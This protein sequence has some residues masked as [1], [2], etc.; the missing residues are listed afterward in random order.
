MAASFQPINVAT[1]LHTN[2]PWRRD[3]PFG[4]Q[5]LPLDAG[6]LHYVDE[7]PADAERTLLFVHGNPT[8]SFHWRRLIVGLRDAHRC[9]AIDHLGCGLSD[10]PQRGFRLA[11]RVEHLGRLVDELDLRRVTLVAQDWGGAIG[12][13]ALLDR[14][15]RLDRVLLFNTGAWPPR[16]V[17]ARIAVCKTPVLGKLALQGANLFSLAALRMTLNRTRLDAATAEAYL[18]PYNNW[19]NRRAVYEFVADIPRNSKHPT[20]QTLAGIESRLPELKGLPLRLV[21]GMRDW[22]FD[23]RCLARFREIWHDAAALEVHELADAGHWV[24]EDAPEECIEQL[25]SFEPFTF[26]AAHFITYAGD[27]CEPLHGHNYRVSV[28]IDGP[29]DENGY[30]R[31]FVAT[32]DS[33]AEL[34]GRLDHRVLLPT[35]HPLIRVQ[36]AEGPLGAAEVVATF[37][38]RRWVFPADECALLPIANTTAELIATWLA[39]QW[40]ADLAK[41]GQAPPPS[42]VVG[43]DECDGQ[44]GVCRLAR[45]T[46]YVCEPKS[47]ASS[48]PRDESPRSAIDSLG[49]RRLGTRRMKVEHIN[50]F[51]KAVTTTFETMLAADVHRGELTLGDPKIRQFPVSGLIGLS[52]KASG[53]VVINLSAEAA[54]QAASAMLMEEQ[55]EL[56]DDVLDAIGELANVIAGQAKA[57]LEEYDLSVGL[58]SVVT[59]EGHEIRFPSSTPPLAV[60]FKTDFGPIRLEVGFEPSA[61]PG[62]PPGRTIRGDVRRRAV[63][64]FQ[65]S[66]GA[67]AMSNAH[68]AAVLLTSL[69]EE[70][71]GQLLSLMEPHDVE[72]VSIEIARLDR[73]SNEEQEQVIREFSET[74]PAASGAG[75]GFDYAKKLVK[76]ALGK[77]SGDAIDN[78]RQSVEA[79]PFGFLRNIDSQNILTYIVDEHPQTIALI[80][81]HLP[82]SFGAEILSGLPA[83]RQLAVVRRMATMGQT[84]PEIIKE[85]EAGLERRMSSVM[86]QSF[87]MAGGVESV[88]AMLNVSDRATERNLLEGLGADD[89]ELV[90]EIRRLMFV[91]DDI[92]R[93]GPKEMQ[94]VMKSVESSQWALALKGASPELKDK[95]LSSMSQRAADMLR[96]EMEYLGAVKLSAVEDQQQQIV[97]VIRGLEDAGEL[98]LNQSGEEEELVQ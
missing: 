80:I 60:P 20:W 82:A 35:Q 14:Q 3:Y 39:E 44:V 21:W 55:T 91:F 51:L 27:T 6:R 7:G 61:E 74:N 15:E 49:T 68:N 34:I 28:E 63:S 81:S 41:S 26:A 66:S 23:P 96:E 77:D 52:G 58:P 46:T 2:A 8:W 78:L 22:C 67:A 86:S 11:D 10:K 45:E 5:W 13:G 9:V 32:R 89:P 50:P 87:Q 48:L 62:K 70:Q 33:W 85:V 97:D 31:D 42:L 12:L 95:V 65:V 56:N 4:S 24:V 37:R 59:G 53:M 94:T 64:L 71:A 88:A 40:L 79:L 29:L 47:C 76:Q 75:G 69:P 25:Q 57:D 19:A 38:D 54:L 17:P 83:E 16:W 43:V 98:D 30:V 72:Q 93:F 92:G 84:N 1:N 90:E 18:A 36:Q 73:V